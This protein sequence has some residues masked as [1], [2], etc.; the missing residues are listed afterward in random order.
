MSPF[1]IREEL[2]IS[3]DR[4]AR[5]AGVSTVTASMYESDEERLQT[6]SR[7]RLHAVYAILSETLQQL[8]VRQRGG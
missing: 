8:R 4:V 2:G 7:A 5:W 1:K 3:R 6:E